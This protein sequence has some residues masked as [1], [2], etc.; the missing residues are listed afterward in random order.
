MN[1]EVA[2]NSIVVP[3]PLTDLE[4]TLGLHVHVSPWISVPLI[5]IVWVLVLLTVK[6]IAF[7]IARK[8]ASNTKTQ[9]DDVLF[10]A[11]DFPLQLM[12]YATGI[13][14]V[15]PLIPKGDVDIIK[16]FL[17]GFKSVGIFAAALF[18]DKFLRGIA[19]LYIEKID[20][21]HVSGGVVRGVIRAIVMGLGALIIL[22]SLG[23]SI[24]PIIASLGIG[25][26]AVALALQPTLENFF[27]G[28]QLLIDKPVQIGQFIRLESGEEGKVERIGWRSTWICLGNNNTVV[29][30]NKLLVNSRVTNFFYPNTEIAVP[31]AVGVHYGSDLEKVEKVTL[32]VARDVQKQME[33][34]VPAAD[35]VV[36]YHAFG[37]FSVNFNVVLRA[38][39][40]PSVPVIKHEFI[41]RLHKRFAQEGISIPYPTHTVI[42][43]NNK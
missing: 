16:Y 34:G 26:L 19:T 1:S 5:F 35:P 18:A 13:L 32:E 3:Q 24:T 30:P 9:L 22:D 8:F 23:V 12:I 14:V 36:R 10:D 39:D 41:K 2:L 31:V 33:G 11:L 25:S 29:I 27:A 43:E 20:I 28:I 40:F 38:K 7:A 15:L 4:R 42:Q 6:K 37:D 17:I 21:L